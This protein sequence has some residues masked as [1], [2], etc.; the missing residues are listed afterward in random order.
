MLQRVRL[1]MQ[2]D[3]KGGKLSGEVEIDETFIG[4]KARNMHDRRRLK[5][6]TGKGGG[7]VGKIGVQGFLERGGQI[8]ATSSTIAGSRALSRTMEENVEKAS[9]LY[10]PIKLVFRASAI[11][12]TTLSI[13]PRCMSMARSIRTAWRTSGAC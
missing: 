4:G 10:R 3:R 9:R 7:T 6:W 2:D 13:T 11:M 12:S 8:R 1:A 5:S